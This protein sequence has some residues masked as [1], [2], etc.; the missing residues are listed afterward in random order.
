MCFQ[1]FVFL[2]LPLLETLRRFAGGS[3]EPESEML[4]LSELSSL[5]GAE[6]A[7]AVRDTRLGRAGGLRFR[8]SAR[9][10]ANLCCRS[11]PPVLA[12]RMRLLWIA[13]NRAK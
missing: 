2:L 13:V 8:V 10:M 4:K 12:R 6:L 1:G 3:T 11:F 9:A 7:D 5:S